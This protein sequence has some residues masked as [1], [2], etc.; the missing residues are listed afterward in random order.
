[1]DTIFMN[2]KNSK[3]FA[4]HRLLLNLTDKIDLTRKDK[5]IALSYLNIYY[6]SKNIKKTYNKNN[7][8]KFQLQYRMKNLN[9]LMGHIVY[10]ILKIILNLKK[11][12]KKTVNPSIRIYLNK[13]KIELLLK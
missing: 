11:A 12:W 3:T 1:M 2:S 10:Q 8:F 7:K 13:L 4:P 5:Y 9:Y 6:T